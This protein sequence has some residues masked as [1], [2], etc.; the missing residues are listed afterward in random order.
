MYISEMFTRD[1][2]STV[3]FSSKPSAGTHRA[4]GKRIGLSRK[5]DREISFH[6]FSTKEI[7]SNILTARVK[8]SKRQPY[9]WNKISFFEQKCQF[10][11]IRWRRWCNNVTYFKLQNMSQSYSRDSWFAFLNRGV[12]SWSNRSKYSMLNHRAQSYS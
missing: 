11:N 1:K 2:G 6:N 8:M 9:F 4:N 10:L 12:K 3:R 7:L 5:K